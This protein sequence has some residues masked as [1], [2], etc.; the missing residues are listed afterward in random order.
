LTLLT[1]RVVTA[2][3]PSNIGAL[4]LSRLKAVLSCLLLS[5][6]RKVSRRQELVDQ[7]LVLANTITEHAAMITIGV[8]APLYIDHVS[9]LVSY[10][11]L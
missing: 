2:R 6:S 9:R 3:L 7:G 5:F 11:G 8:Q 1:V 4:Q 10:D